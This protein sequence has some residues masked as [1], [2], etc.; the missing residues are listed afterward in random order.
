MIIV[1]PGLALLFVRNLIIRD[2]KLRQHRIWH[3]LRVLRDHCRHILRIL[4]RIVSRPQ[5]KL[6]PKP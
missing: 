1:I 6:H 2:Q 3:L 4:R 5:L